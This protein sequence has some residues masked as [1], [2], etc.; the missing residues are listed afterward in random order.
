VAYDE[1]VAATLRAAL[2][3]REGVEE[4]RMFGALCFMLRGNMLCGALSD[5]GFFRVGKQGE[6]TALAQPGVARMAMRDRPMPGIVR[7]PA[8]SVAD[9]GRRAELLGLALAFVDPLPRK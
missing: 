7:V 9:P 2:A 1:A 6:P 3:G 5:G 4:R 8:T